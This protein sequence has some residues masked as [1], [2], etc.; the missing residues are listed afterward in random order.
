MASFRSINMYFPDENNDIG[1]TYEESEEAV[2]QQ[3]A[4]QEDA[5]RKAMAQSIQDILAQSQRA[6]DSERL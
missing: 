5:R 3:Q 4:A 2:R 1:L 6:K